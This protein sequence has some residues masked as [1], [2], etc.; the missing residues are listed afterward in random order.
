MKTVIRSKQFIITTIQECETY[1]KKDGT[2]YW[3]GQEITTMGELR[4]ILINFLKHP[5]HKGYSTIVITPVMSAEYINYII[6]K[7][8]RKRIPLLL[9]ILL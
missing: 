5:I 9:S 4:E 2:I 7:T 3:G 8:I 6:D 1:L